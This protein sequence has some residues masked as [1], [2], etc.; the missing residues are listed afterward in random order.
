MLRGL[1][2][3]LAAPRQRTDP[4]FYE[5][6]NLYTFLRDVGEYGTAEAEAQKK[7][8]LI[9]KEQM[10]KLDE[11]AA[12][13]GQQSALER[14]KAVGPLYRQMMKPKAEDKPPLE[15]RSLKYY[16]GVLA[17]PN[18]SP[19][20]K[21]DAQIMVKKILSEP[22]EK[23][24][25]QTWNDRRV[26]AYLR[27]SQGKAT[28]EDKVVISIDK[29]K[30]VTPRQ[31][32]KDREILEAR[33]KTKNL[34]DQELRSLQLKSRYDPNAKETLRLWNLAQRPTYQEMLD[35]INIE[36]SSNVIE[37]EMP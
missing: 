24:E 12:K 33:E 10:L 36:A 1:A 7:A 35:D 18:A 2:M 31:E 14:L 8:E 20:D 32:A 37:E 27:E 28:P 5:K 6:R 13:Y 21:A 23:P 11:L 16:R 29:G 3:S 22:T 15:A 19:E 9:Q 4:R 26:Q 17:D 30:K 25:R 34:N